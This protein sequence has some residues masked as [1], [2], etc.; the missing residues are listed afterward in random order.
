MCCVR[1]RRDT[2]R[3]INLYCIDKLFIIYIFVKRNSVFKRNYAE[4]F[5]VSCGTY[6]NVISR[7]LK[8]NRPIKSTTEFLL[9]LHIVM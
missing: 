4:M 7:A 3:Q 1:S 2:M 5:D 9:K 8:G 6:S